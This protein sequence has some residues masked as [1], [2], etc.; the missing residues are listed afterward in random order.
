MTPVN[1][2]NKVMYDKMV[3]LFDQDKYPM[4]VELG[5]ALLEKSRRLGD[6]ASEKKALEVLALASYYLVDYISALTYIIQFSKMIKKDDDVKETIRVYSAFAIIYTRQGNYVEAKKLFEKASR[7]A[8]DND[9]NLQQAKIEINFGFFYNTAGEFA[10]AISHLEKAIAH[11]EYNHFTELIPIIYGNLA[12]SY[13]RTGRIQKAKH[14]LDQFFLLL[15]NDK[16]GIATAEAYMYRG[17]VHSIEGNYEDAVTLIKASMLISVKNS[18]IKELAEATRMLSETYVKLGDYKNAYD[19]IIDYMPLKET[20]FKKAKEGALVELKMQYEL[21][22]K[23]VEADA[24]RLQNAVLEE[25]N[26]KIQEQKREM[27]RLN[28]VLG[29]QNDDL[30]QA[31]IEDYL[32]GVYNRRYFTLKMQEEYSIAKEHQRNIA[33][34]VFDIDKFKSIN[35]T[36]GHLAGDE[37]IKHISNICE[38]SLDTDSIIGRFGGD[39]FMILM[40]DADIDEA[41]SKA[42]ELIENIR[43]EPLVIDKKSVSVTIS[44]GVSDNHFLN[45]RT[46]DEMIHIADKG[47]YIAKEQG[48]NRC[49]RIEQI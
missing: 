35:D 25:Q 32:T 46:T 22:K 15:K 37:I 19:Q 30:H 3:D 34:I 49:C 39:E 24:L 12:L 31:A 13:I 20:L 2:L 18:Y 4:A 9:L 1:K 42:E 6:E 27:E 16:S 43:L 17:E 21:N 48:R 7:L 5:K 36:Y 40:V 23:E 44:L 38:E 29:R 28:R 8:Y 33:C 14:T 26:G 11:S 45:P 47:L 41:Q 10:K